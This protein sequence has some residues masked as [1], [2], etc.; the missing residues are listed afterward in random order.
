MRDGALAV[1]AR[2]LVAMAAPCRRDI[3]ARDCAG[4]I[5]T[6]CPNGRGGAARCQRQ[7]DCCCQHDRRDSVDDIVASGERQHAELN[8]TAVSGNYAQSALTD[9]V[10]KVAAIFFLVWLLSLVAFFLLANREFRPTFS[11]LDQRDGGR[12]HKATNG[13]SNPTRDSARCFS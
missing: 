8:A 13:T 12:V 7:C 3:A 10:S 1:V 9:T 11:K 5:G 6:Q 4:R 2:S